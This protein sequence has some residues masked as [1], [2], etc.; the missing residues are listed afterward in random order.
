M[1]AQSNIELEPIS[2]TKTKMLADLFIYFPLGG[3]LE[4]AIA[5]WPLDFLAS[6]SAHTAITVRS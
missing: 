4:L 2:K 6:G 3:R 1:P 5:I